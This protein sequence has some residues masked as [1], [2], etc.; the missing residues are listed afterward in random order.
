MM[1]LVFLCLWI[2]SIGLYLL[3]RLAHRLFLGKLEK[4][5]VMAVQR[6][7]AFVDR[8]FLSNPSDN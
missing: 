8:K 5:L 2:C 4:L 3:Y 6:V 1:V 7:I